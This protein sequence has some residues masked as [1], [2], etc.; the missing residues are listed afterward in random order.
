MRFLQPRNTSSS[1]C[2]LPLLIISLALLIVPAVASRGDRLPEFKEC[3]QGCNDKNC[4]FESTPLPLHLRLL[5]WNCPSECDYQCQRSITASRAAHGQRIEQFHGKWPFRRILGI[6]EPFSVLFSILNGHAHYMGLKT[7]NREIPRDYPLKKYYQLYSCFGIFCWIWSTVFHT[8]DFTFT[9]RMDYFGAGA[10]VLYGLYYTPLRIW[11]IYKPAHR[12]ILKIWTIVCIAAY[13]AHV[14]YLTCIRWDYAYNMAA[15]VFVGTVQNLCWTYFSFGH[16][17]KLKRF[18][19][20]WPGL[21]VM[22]LIMAMSLELLDFPPIFDAIDAHSLWHAMTI[23]PLIFWYKFLIK[24]ARQ[25][26]EAGEV[27]TRLKA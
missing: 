23:L 10:N 1:R 22:W 13:L 24:D 11:R 4:L 27:A 18:W 9:E 2:L 6:Q 5:L 26:V 15:N 21:I 16:Y 17:S 3:V 8:R 12:N 19:A 20:A 14:C 25:D 7:I